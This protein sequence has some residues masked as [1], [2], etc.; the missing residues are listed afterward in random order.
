MPIPRR[1][2]QTGKSRTLSPLARASATNLKL[3]H[4]D[5]EYIY[6][7]DADVGRFIDTEF[8]EH[9]EAFD[10][11]P[12]NIQRFD[13]FRY[14]A[15]F[16]LGGFY[17]DTDVLLYEPLD[18]LLSGTAV[19]PFEE[20]TLNAHL[21]R[22]GIDWEIGNYAFGAAQSEPFLGRVIENCVRSLH[23][24]SWASEMLH[25]IPGA[26][27]AGF[28]VLCT[29]GPAML[30]RTLVE[31]SKFAQNVTVLF[32][33]DVCDPTHWH[34]FGRY[35]THLMEGTWRV[36]G[37]FLRRRL[38]WLWADRLQR[39]LLADSRL[40]GPVRAVPQSQQ[41]RAVIAGDARG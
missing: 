2:I 34:Q 39:Q 6:F 29:T 26:F 3:L 33:P 19:F 17:F 13:F 40:R 7:D 41:P 25:G 1:I 32:P 31:N 28:E 21:R 24:T 36:K 37:G 12:Q 38:G 15:I 20:I 30:S 11:F 4:P 18:E 8:P 14:L 9:R 5:W 23:D 27:R 22:A 10:A 35:G 16:R